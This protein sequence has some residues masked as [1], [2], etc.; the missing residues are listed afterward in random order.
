MAGRVVAPA[1][2]GGAV[3]LAVLCLDGALPSASGGLT[4]P[5]RAESVLPAKAS[6]TGGRCDE[7]TTVTCL[8]LQKWERPYALL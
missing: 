2:A 8:V 3:R 4:P 1:S 5:F 7:L 6:L